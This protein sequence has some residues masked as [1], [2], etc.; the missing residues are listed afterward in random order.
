MITIDNELQVIVYLQNGRELP[1]NPVA[2]HGAQA[3]W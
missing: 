3:G 1:R 2:D